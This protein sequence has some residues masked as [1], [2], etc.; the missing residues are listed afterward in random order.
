MDSVYLPEELILDIY[1]KLGSSYAINVFQ[2][3]SLLNQQWQRISKDHKLMAYR[4]CYKCKR[5]VDKDHIGCLIHNKYLPLKGVYISQTRTS[6][7]KGHLKIIKY[8]FETRLDAM[9]LG[10]T[11]IIA[12]VAQKG[13]ID[14][15]RYLCEMHDIHAFGLGNAIEIAAQDGQINIIK[16]LC[17]LNI[18]HE[19]YNDALISASAYGHLDIVIYLCELGANVHTEN[20]RAVI[21]ASEYG[22][23][24]IVKYLC[25][26]R[27]ANMHADNDY[28]VNMAAENCHVEV[29]KYLCE[30]Y[31]CIVRLKW[32]DMN[33]LGLDINSLNTI[34]SRELAMHRKMIIEA[35]E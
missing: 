21:E 13:H 15:L 25:E 26:L 29:V 34:C 30:S 7:I 9:L 1:H 28:A 5:I 6:L 2:C 18:K 8:L 16:Y 17:S 3:L 22:Y 23:L 14:I 19:Q 10:H 20:D 31:D 12:I 33:W 24:D 4:V 27:G 35:E 11:H 32:F